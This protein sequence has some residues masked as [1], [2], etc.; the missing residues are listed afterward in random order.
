MS[1][2][3]IDDIALSGNMF[4]CNNC[5]VAF[6][7]FTAKCFPYW[8]EA[9]MT[10]TTIDPRTNEVTVRFVP[11]IFERTVKNLIW[12]YDSGLKLNIYGYPTDGFTEVHFAHEDSVE[13]YAVA[14]TPVVPNNE[15]TTTDNTTTDTTTD[16]TDTTDTTET[17]TE[18][19]VDNG[20]ENGTDS[21]TETTPET[22]ETTTETEST[23]EESYIQVLIPDA[24][25][26]VAGNVN[27]YL[28]N[29]TDESSVTVG[30][31]V[32]NVNP[33]EMVT[34]RIGSS[35]TTTVGLGHAG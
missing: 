10:P 3:T 32:L 11:G 31:I 24:C 17:G 35:T 25:L 23:E 30:L 29:K 8:R 14:V 22:T 21:G 4:R 15:D 2:Y 18:T 19:G 27:C 13:V 20:V 33:R 5:A 16:G 28:V 9:V 34:T 12:Q 7:E 26:T 6:S 1:H